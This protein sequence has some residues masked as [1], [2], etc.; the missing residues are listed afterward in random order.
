MTPNLP[1]DDFDRSLVAIRDV[2]SRGDLS[3]ALRIWSE[4]RALFG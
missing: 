3:S 2:V 4:L 1:I